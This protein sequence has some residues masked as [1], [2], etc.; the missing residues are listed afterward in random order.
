MFLVWRLG[1]EQ[2][3]EKQEVPTGTLVWGREGHSR[4]GQCPR[5]AGDCEGIS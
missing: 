5:Q 4:E 2:G 1:Q 3:Q